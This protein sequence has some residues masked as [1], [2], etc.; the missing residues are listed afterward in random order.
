MLTVVVQALRSRY[1]RLA[2]LRY[3]LVRLHCRFTLQN[4]RA[5]LAQ[6][7]SVW[8]MKTVSQTGRR[9][10]VRVY[11]DHGKIEKKK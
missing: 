8:T 10:Q 7:V 11:Y 2:I 5:L 4:W 3:R 9:N 6:S 1:I